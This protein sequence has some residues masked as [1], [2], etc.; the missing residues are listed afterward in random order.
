MYL[1]EKL[2]SFSKEFLSID[3]TRP[4]SKSEVLTP[5]QTQTVEELLENIDQTMPNSVHIWL[6]VKEPNLSEVLRGLKGLKGQN[7][8]LKRQGTYESDA[9][10]PIK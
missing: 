6:K 2:N 9:K 7:M 10:K 1:T 3:F 5:K 8:L 4:Q